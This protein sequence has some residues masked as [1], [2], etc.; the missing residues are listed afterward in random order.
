MPNR[1]YPLQPI[2]KLFLT[3]L[4]LTLV[5]WALRAFTWLAFLPGLVL[6]TLI[7]ACFSLGIISSL[8]RMR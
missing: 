7:L 8:Q 1:S 3:V 5:V 4:I 6:W 2:T